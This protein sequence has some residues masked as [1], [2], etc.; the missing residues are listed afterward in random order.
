MGVGLGFMARRTICRRAARSIAQPA[1]ASS[2]SHD[3]YTACELR[4]VDTAQARSARSAAERRRCLRLLAPHYY[5]GAL[6]AVG[7]RRF[8]VAHGPNGG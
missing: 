4:I 5:L 6:Q 1:P 2:V 7:E 8:Y 3:P